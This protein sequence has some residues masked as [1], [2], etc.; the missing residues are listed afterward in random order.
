MFLLA[1]PKISSNIRHYDS[2]LYVL[3]YLMLI[4]KWVHWNNTLL[5]N[6]TEQCPCCEA[7]SQIPCLQLNC[8]VHYCN[9]RSLALVCVLSYIN[10]VHAL[11]PVSLRSI[12]TIFSCSGLGFPS[13]LFSLSFPPKLC[14]H[15]WTLSC[16]LHAAPVLSSWICSPIWWTVRSLKVLVMQFS[17]VFCCFFA[18]RYRYS[19]KQP[20]YKEPQSSTRYTDTFP[21]MH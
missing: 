9:R 4:N 7:G 5:I 19:P 17:P 20:V 16:V 13:T 15:F 3:I 10:P 11:S 14:L 1:S 21:S 8:G 18:L 6:R 12:L 2:V